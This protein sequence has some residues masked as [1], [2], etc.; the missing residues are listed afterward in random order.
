MLDMH[1]NVA[2]AL[3]SHLKNREIDAY[4]SLES[5]IVTKVPLTN[6]S[7]PMPSVPRNVPDNLNFF[8]CSHLWNEMQSPRS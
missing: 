1:T 8:V 6:I 4:Y 2:T 5:D 3:L 7:F